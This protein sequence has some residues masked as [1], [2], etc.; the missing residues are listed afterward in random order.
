[1]VIHDIASLQVQVIGRH[2]LAAL[3]VL[4][5]GNHL[6]VSIGDAVHATT[7]GDS[8]V[9]V[10]ADDHVDIVAV[11]N[12]ERVV[13]FGWLITAIADVRDHDGIVHPLHLLEIAGCGIGCIGGKTIA[14]ILTV[15][16]G[17]QPRGVDV[18]AEETDALIAHGLDPVGMEQA[19]ERSGAEVIVGAHL[20]GIHVAVVCGQ[21][22]H[23]V[24]KLMVAQDD[25]VITQRV[26]Q[27]IFHLA[28]VER[29]EQSALDGVTG[30]DEGRVGVG[31]TQVVVDGAAPGHTALAV[32]GRV[33]LAVCV[34]NCDNQQVLGTQGGYRHQ[35]A[36]A[37]EHE[38]ADLSHNR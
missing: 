26:H 1:M 19:V 12:D 15:H 34:I 22:L 24:V 31:G 21:L 2:E 4:A 37:H 25:R 29:E 10:G 11:A 35:R 36:Q 7:R 32:A 5:D 33:N 8:G 3:A 17:N 16:V 30:V 20:H 28:A 13:G 38:V 18:D 6:A 14:Q 23:A 9:G 27:R